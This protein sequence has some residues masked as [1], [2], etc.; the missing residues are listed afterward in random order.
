MNP[1][2]PI[3]S[4][5]PY[6]ITQHGQTRVDDYFWLRE[7]ENPETMAYLKAENKYLKQML[8]HTAALQERLFQEMKGRIPESDVSAPQ[9]RGEYFYYTRM[10]PQKQY[11][12]YCRKKDSQRA[13]IAEAVEEVLLDQNALAKGHAYCE[14]GGFEVSPDHSKL[15]YLLDTEGGETYTLYVKDLKSGKLFSEAIPNIGGLLVARIGLA[16]AR[17][18]KTLYYSTLDAT[19]RPYRLYRHKLGDDPAQDTLIYEETDTLFS[20]AIQPSRSGVY[21]WVMLSTT[22]SIEVR[23]ISLTQ[24][25][26]RSKSIRMK[27]IL[28]RQ[29]FIEYEVDHQGERFLILTNEGAQNFRLMSAP[30]RTPQRKYWQEILPE[31]ADVTLE[32]LL[33]FQNDL[34]LIERKDGLRQVRIS[35]LDGTSHVRYIS[36]PEPAYVLWPDQNPEAATRTLRFSYSS[37]VTPHSVIDYDM[38]E[39]HWDMVKQDLIPSGYDASLY[40]TERLYATAADGKRVPISL[41]YRKGMQRT[42]KNPLLL[43]GYGSYGFSMDPNFNSNRLS[44]LDRGFIFAIAHVRGGS[45][46]GRAWYEDGKLLKKKNTFT[47]FIAC[48]EHLISEGYTCREKLVIMGGSAGGLLVGAVMAMRPDLCQAV[49]ADVPFVDVVNTMSD[50][51]IP[52]TTR[53]YDQWG[54]PDD[55]QDFEYMLSYSPYDNL[56]KTAYPHILLITGLNDPRV[57][58][59]EP[60]KFCAKLRSLKTNDNL[61]LLKTDFATGH[62]GASGRY[63]ALKDVALIYAFVLDRVGS[64]PE[65]P[66]PQ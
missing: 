59:W 25:A 6:P 62:G 34:V 64:S 52:L 24:Q 8:A 53:E 27:T 58:F 21:L 29:P 47:D 54:N 28:P 40:Q 5:H 43:N 36:M 23:Y 33:C 57:A 56:R 12:V 17:D 65:Q 7:R 35:A 3:A 55:P 4:R 26:S 60:A 50:P 10:E 66:S 9:K 63:N 14:L 61:V 13:D 22:S 32:R 37:L 15:A 16:W 38:A 49:V 19:H 45:D 31:R 46:L 41:V 42:G 30:V 18:G 48:A 1:T 20:M 2:P 11:P 51:S 39:G 44:L